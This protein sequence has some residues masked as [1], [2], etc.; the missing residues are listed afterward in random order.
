MAESGFLSV[1][2]EE[3]FFCIGFPV[4]NCGSDL[5]NGLFTSFEFITGCILSMSSL[6]RLLVF[7]AFLDACSNFCSFS[8]C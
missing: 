4:F 7:F 2:F 1:F 6:L 8:I 5:F 3:S